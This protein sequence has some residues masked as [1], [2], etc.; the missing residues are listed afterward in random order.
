MAEDS[1]DTLARLTE[2]LARLDQERARLLIAIQVI[3]GENGNDA[4][5]EQDEGEGGELSLPALSPPPARRA[6]A[7]RPDS[8]FGMTQHQAARRYLQNLRHADRIE[9]ILRAIVSGG[10]E[11]GGASP[12]DTLRAMLGQNTSTFVKVSPGTFGLR[13][14]YPHLGNKD[15]KAAR[16]VKPKK[17]PK[18]KAAPKP[19]R[20]TKTKPE[21][22]A[23]EQKG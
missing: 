16:R 10:V 15:V 21:P 4:V 14:F 19:R 3:K 22:S 6:E 17:K 9:N 8:F 13:E 1:Q 2:R 18:K 20:P 12:L 5:P 23:Q 11:V 7:I